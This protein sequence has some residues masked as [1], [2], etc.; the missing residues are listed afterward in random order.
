MCD[1]CGACFHVDAPCYNEVVGVPYDS[2]VGDIFCRGC[3][4]AS[5]IHSTSQC[6]ATREAPAAAEFEQL[7]SV[8]ATKLNGLAH[9]GDAP[10]YLAALTLYPAPLLGRIDDAEPIP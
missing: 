5:N 10:A 3:C 7:R 1:N 6:L 4:E 8:F 9:Q 2:S